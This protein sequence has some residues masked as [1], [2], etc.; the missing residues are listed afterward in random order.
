MVDWLVGGTISLIFVG[1]C[2]WALTHH[3]LRS[4]RLARELSGV[5]PS[6]WVCDPDGRHFSELEFC[7][8]IHNQVIVDFQIIPFFSRAGLSSCSS[9]E[10]AWLYGIYVGSRGLYALDDCVVIVMRLRQDACRPFLLQRCVGGLNEDPG[11]ER[12]QI[13]EKVKDNQ[14]RW[15]QAG[16]WMLCDRVG[17]QGGGFIAKQLLDSGVPDHIK[18]VQVEGKYLFVFGGTMLSKTSYTDLLKSTEGILDVV[19]RPQ[20]GV[21]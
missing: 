9:Q 6:E 21:S 15:W 16:D 13:I 19:C 8:E 18:A 17:H 4:R 10:D 14:R 1:A 7:Q 2:V 12:Y 20:D 11:D 3:R 5:L